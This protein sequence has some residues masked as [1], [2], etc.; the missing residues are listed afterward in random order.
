LI[1][2]ATFQKMSRRS[3]VDGDKIQATLLLLDTEIWH[4]RVLPAYLTEDEFK[5]VRLLHGKF[6]DSRVELPLGGLISDA[7]SLFA[8]LFGEDVPLHPTDLS[9]LTMELP[10]MRG[11]LSLQDAR[12]WSAAP[13]ACRTPLII[14]CACCLR[15]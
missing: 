3:S 8:W 9:T 7:L 4:T 1:K 10:H 11:I 2:I 5:V 12:K 15:T 14:F 13:V 6:G